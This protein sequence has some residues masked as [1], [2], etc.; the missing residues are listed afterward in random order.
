M[1]LNNPNFYIFIKKIKEINNQNL[2]KFKNCAIIYNERINT[3]NNLTEIHKIKNFCKKN[4]L[5]L[6][7]LNDF[8]LAHKIRAE[9]I[10]L[11]SDN[12]LIGRGRLENKLIIIGSAHNQI[13]YFYK[14][15][16]FCRTIILSP[17]FYNVKYSIHK[18]LNLRKFNL[19]SLNWNNEI[20][21]LGGI[22]DGNFK[23]I[24]LTKSN[25]I[26]FS[27]FVTNAKKP[28]YRLDKRAF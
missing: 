3:S 23:L 26:G 20:C 21:A 25:S 1:L 9:G 19:I 2:K 4:H 6:F 5:S 12:R 18:I 24:S 17:I 27:S 22:N 14:N 10:C 15:N 16:Q 28:V 11:T 13:E 7:I 8:K